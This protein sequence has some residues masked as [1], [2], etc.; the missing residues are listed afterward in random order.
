MIVH[1]SSADQAV[2]ASSRAVIST[3][4]LAAVRAACGP[5]IGVAACRQQRCHLRHRGAIVSA[6]FATFLCFP[7]V[8]LSKDIPFTDGP[9]S[10]ATIQKALAGGGMENVSCRY[11]QPLIRCV[12]YRQLKRSSTYVRATMVVH[13]TAARRGWALECYGLLGVCER[14]P[15]TLGRKVV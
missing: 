10:A 1:G 3:H 5:Q 11:R 12:Y 6:V 8:S 15:L 14:K 9:G 7:G 2:G 4:P 13:K